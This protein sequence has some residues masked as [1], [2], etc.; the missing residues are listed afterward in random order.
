MPFQT[1]VRAAVAVYSG[2]SADRFVR[3][4]AGL[5]FIG[6]CGL[7][8][9]AVRGLQDEDVDPMKLIN[10]ISELQ[11]ALQAD[12]L[13]AR[14]GAEKELL[15]MG[16][17]ALDYLPTVSAEQPTDMQERLQR[18]RTGLERLAVES[19]S[20]PST[21]TLK[22]KHK[23]AA[24]LAAIRKQTGNNVQLA[25][26][27]PGELEDRD[28]EANWEAA[29]FWTVLGEIGEKTG[30]YHDRFSGEPG[31]LVFGGPGSGGVALPCRTSSS[32]LL[33]ELLRA[34][35]A[36]NFES[37]QTNATLLRLRV[38]WEPRLEPIAL[39][40]PMSTVAIIDEF[41]GEYQ[42]GTPD[43]VAGIM[44]Q[45]EFSQSEMSLALPLFDRGVESLKSLSGTFEMTVPGRIETFE[46]EGLAGLAE[47]TRQTRAGATVSFGGISDNLDL[48]A[49]KLSLSFDQPEDGMESHLGWAQQNEVFLRRKDGER[50]DPIAS[51]TWQQAEFLYGVTYLFP[52]IPD[53]AVLVYRTP[54]AIVKLQVPFVLLGIPLP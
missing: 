6:L 9:S 30:I 26:D 21:I 4:L 27:A 7:C 28:I 19:V 29:E 24:V 33:L 13:A 51:E 48:K 39:R 23:I 3:L 11:V 44:I 49:L 46:F 36:R 15:A 22:G 18:V 31:L 40:L 37:P 20:K 5:L 1:V 35:A 8:S 12:D 52:E 34:D 38:S 10:R 43:Q 45:P 25:G 32:V 14:D 53:D 47:D 42:A 16:P 54:A 17:L 41:D 2:S 50:L